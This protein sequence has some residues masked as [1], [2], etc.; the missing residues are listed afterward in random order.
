M[1]TSAAAINNFYLKLC[2]NVRRFY[3]QL[4]MQ[5]DKDSGK[6]QKTLKATQIFPKNSSLFGSEEI[7]VKFAEIPNDHFRKY[8]RR[9]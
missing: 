7:N 4:N 3:Q 5:L 2:E 1:Q 6:W 9:P 8:K